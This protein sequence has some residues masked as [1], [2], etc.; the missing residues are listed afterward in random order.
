VDG[1]LVLQPLEALER[2]FD[3]CRPIFRACGN[4]K[5]VILSP[6]LHYITVE[7][8]QNEEHAPN[9]S[10]ENF[11][12]TFISGLERTKK[13]IKTLAEKARLPNCTVYNPLWLIGG[14]KK[15]SEAEILNIIEQG[16]GTHQKMDVQLVS[17][18]K[19]T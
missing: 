11:R 15:R 9:Q 19:S 13:Y 2:S 7:S 14:P 16:W 12:S 5:V 3:D 4:N 6:L 18:S 10:E 1:D 17:I 8:C